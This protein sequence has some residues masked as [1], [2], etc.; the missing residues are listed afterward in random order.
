MELAEVAESQN[1]GKILAKAREKWIKIFQKEWEAKKYTECAQAVAVLKF[2]DGQ[3]A[4]V[5]G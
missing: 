5:R 1:Y 4:G 3:I 2:I